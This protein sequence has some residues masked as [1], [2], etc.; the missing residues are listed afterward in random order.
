MFLPTTFLVVLSW[1]SFLMDRREVVA[2]TILVL[3]TLFAMT[4]IST[5][6]GSA[7]PYV[8]SVRAM[9]VWVGTC[10]TFLLLALLEFA[11]V[12]S[13]GSSEDK[14]DSKAEERSRGNANSSLNFEIQDKSSSKAAFSRVCEALRVPKDSGRIDSA[15][16]ILFPAAFFTF[17][18]IYIIMYYVCDNSKLN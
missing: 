1:T 18:F 5:S 8:S 16:R 13:V 17:V 11:V 6:I 9:D 10:F 7:V 3:S 12:T 2:R 15:A 14:A 4:S